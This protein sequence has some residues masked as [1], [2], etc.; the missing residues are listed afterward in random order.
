MI[1][2]E[3]VLL[4]NK[5]YHKELAEELGIK[6]PNVTMWLKK[7]KNIPQKYLPILSEKFNF[8]EDY[9]QKEVDISQILNLIKYIHIGGKYE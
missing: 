2:L 9:F 1:G 6:D 5:M 4:L 8:P 3:L 7:Q